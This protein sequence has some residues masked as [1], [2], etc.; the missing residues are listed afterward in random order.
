MSKSPFSIYR[1]MKPNRYALGIEISD[2]AV[3][4]A[5]VRIPAKGLPELTYSAVERLPKDAVT[6]GRIQDKDEVL[7]A[8]RK[9]ASR[10][11]LRSRIVHMILPGTLV[12]VRFMKMPDLPEAE[13]RKVVDFE[14]R[15]NMHLPF[16]NPVYDFA[17]INGSSRPVKAK[18]KRKPQKAER[19]ERP[20]SPFAGL[21]EAAA[22]LEPAFG[23]GAPFT[24]ITDQ[25][26]NEAATQCDVMLAAA[27]RE[28]VNEYADVVREAGFKLRSMEIKPLS[29][30][31]LL[32]AKQEV[33]TGGTM[34]VVDV[35]ENA[36][37]FCVFF[38]SELKIT[39]NIPVSFS[40][41]AGQPPVS[42]FGESDSEFGFR[43]ACFDLA[44]EIE[45][46][47]NFYRYS[48]NHRE[49]E[50]DCILILGDA[51][52]L[53]EIGSLL[54]ERITTEVRLMEPATISSAAPQ[55]ERQFPALAV[56]IGLAL[57]ESSA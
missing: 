47:M 41:D 57:R 4:L 3:K 13:L 45:R 37:D 16:D 20:N 43:A 25:T 44:D 46:L 26:Q 24:D 19:A 36:A 53:T 42:L 9:I 14:V 2:Y 51:P 33:R 48:L 6:D 15:H 8:L 5:E 29:L 49:E 10:R 35:G 12:T 50:F 11:Q 17:K 56:P 18:R 54:T 55:F 40:S 1:L 21:D 27:P 31:R 23:A 30:R 7:L 22:A 38:G 32:F 34:M 52:R 39:R 28:Q